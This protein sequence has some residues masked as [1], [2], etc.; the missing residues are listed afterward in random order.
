MTNGRALSSLVQHPLWL[1][2]ILYCRLKALSHLHRKK[3]GCW[4]FLANE[5]FCSDTC[6][7]VIPQAALPPTSSTPTPTLS[8]DLRLA[9][10]TWIGG[11]LTALK[12]RVG[13]PGAKSPWLPWSS[14][15]LF[16]VLVCLGISYLSSGCIEGRV[17]WGGG[18]IIIVEFCTPLNHL[19]KI[20][21]HRSECVIVTLRGKQRIVKTKVPLS[22]TLNLLTGVLSELVLFLSSVA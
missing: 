7:L 13:W 10:G 1:C 12:N 20:R 2:I 5:S 14:N 6:N 18:L 16:P 3:E 17:G 8:L 15:C 11:M 9:T 21:T 19:P 22:N 4:T